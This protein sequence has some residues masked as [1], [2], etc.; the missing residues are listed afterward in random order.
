M[1][2]RLL[3]AFSLIST[4]ILFFGQCSKDKANPHCQYTDCAPGSVSY[5]TD[6]KPIIEQ[7][8]VTNLGPGTGCHDAWIFNY[9]SVLKRVNNGTIP[10]EVVE[11]M[12]M[13][14]IP[15]NFNIQPLSDEQIRKWRCWICDGAPQN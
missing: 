7:H 9:S 1:K 12:D 11:T 10:H 13:P 6:I 2:R 14:P 4:C 8:C 15:N 5:Q 3:L